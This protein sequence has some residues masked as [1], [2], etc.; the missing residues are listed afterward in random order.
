MTTYKSYWLSDA[1][2][3]EGNTAQAA[4]LKESSQVQRV[5]FPLPLREGLGEGRHFI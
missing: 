2:P 4:A 5:H 3:A 1:L